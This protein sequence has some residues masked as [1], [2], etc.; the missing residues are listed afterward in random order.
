MMSS[1]G[2]DDQ[3]LTIDRGWFM[4]R[5]PG[6]VATYMDARVDDASYARFLFALAEDIDGSSLQQRRGVLYEV[7]EPGVVGADRR[8]ALGLLLDARRER[9]G[10]ITA[11]Y[12]LVTPSAIARGVLTAVF[13]LAPPPYETHVNATLRDAFVWLAQRVPQL[14]AAESEHTYLNVRNSALTKMPP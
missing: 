6:I 8:K 14:N 12:V 4:A 9:L 11:G 10:R 1:V 7:P 5:F 3:A 13:W 2:N